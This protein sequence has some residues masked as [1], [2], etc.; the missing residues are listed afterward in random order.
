MYLVEPTFKTL[1]LHNLWFSFSQIRGRD[2]FKN[3]Q[4]LYFNL[5][6]NNQ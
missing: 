1:G 5:D 4:P 2:F 3:Y 6:K